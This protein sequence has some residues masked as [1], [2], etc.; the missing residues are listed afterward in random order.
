MRSRIFSTRYLLILVALVFFGSIIWS[1][2]FETLLPL[3]RDEQWLALLANL[4]GLPL[5]LIGTAGMCWGL[6]VFLR[7]TATFTSAP[8]WRSTQAQLRQVKVQGQERKAA[9]RKMLGLAWAGWKWSVIWLVGGIVLI[10][11]GGIITNLP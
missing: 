7:D 9:Q 2:G 3:L 6:W 11:V 10:I 1:M 8:E 5:I 4:L